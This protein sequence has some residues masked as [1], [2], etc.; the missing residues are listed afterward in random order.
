M[1]HGMPLNLLVVLTFIANGPPEKKTVAS[2]TYRQRRRPSDQRNDERAKNKEFRLSLNGILPKYCPDG[3]ISLLLTGP[4]IFGRNL[5]SQ[6]LL[7][8]T[9]AF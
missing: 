1:L 5:V 4:D 8:T 3:S 9:D 6:T 2:A 7:V